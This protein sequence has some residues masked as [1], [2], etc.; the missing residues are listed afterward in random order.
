VILRYF[1]DGGHGSTEKSLTYFF[2][3]CRTV[4]REWG[5]VRP[6]RIE[7]DSDGVTKQHT[8]SKNAAYTMKI[9]FG[10]FP[11]TDDAYAIMLSGTQAGYGGEGPHGAAAILRF[12]GVPEKQVQEVFK[13]KRVVYVM[14]TDGWI[15]TVGDPKTEEVYEITDKGRMAIERLPPE[16]PN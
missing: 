6:L 16:S 8:S 7:I 13:N 15:H 3:A 2:K 10:I 4:L 1:R 5:V 14:T 12:L 9:L 11:G